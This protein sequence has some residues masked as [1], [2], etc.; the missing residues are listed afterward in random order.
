[1][2]AFEKIQKMSDG[3]MDVRLSPLSNIISINIKGQNGEITIGVDRKTAQDLIDGKKFAGGFLL[4][5]K[6]IY[7]NL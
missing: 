3:N 5:D 4:C 6:E 2:K 1:M 7:D